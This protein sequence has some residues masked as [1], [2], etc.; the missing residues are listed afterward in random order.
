M[1]IKPIGAG[2]V[3]FHDLSEGLYIETG[4]G[5]RI[6]LATTDN[7]IEINV[8]GKDF[9]HGNWWV[10]DFESSKIKKQ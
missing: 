9:P 6:F 5:S 3:A 4:N 7:T 2:A 1:K 8:I 10:I